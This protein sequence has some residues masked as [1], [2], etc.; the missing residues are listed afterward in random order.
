MTKPNHRRVVS[1]KAICKGEPADFYNMNKE[2]K[3]IGR[4]FA[5][6]K[7]GMYEC[8]ITVLVVAIKVKVIQNQPNNKNGYETHALNL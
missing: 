6:L 1:A 5:L 2:S 8:N 3:T 7:L 4:K